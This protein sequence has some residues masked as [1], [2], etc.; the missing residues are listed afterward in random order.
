MD[1]SPLLDNGQL[2]QWLFRRG[3]EVNVIRRGLLRQA[4]AL[5]VAQRKD[6]SHQYW[7]P[8]PHRAR[9]LS[10]MAKTW[11][12][13]HDR[14]AEKAFVKAMRLLSPKNGRRNNPRSR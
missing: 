5:Q 7:W 4:L 2:A 13:K 11:V 14:K 6:D 8:Y 9:T 3:R 10:R 12:S 1:G